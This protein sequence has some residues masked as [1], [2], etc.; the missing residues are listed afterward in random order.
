MKLLLWPEQ[1]RVWI[2]GGWL[3]PTNNIVEIS[4]ISSYQ[5]TVD[6]TTRLGNPTRL[7]TVYFGRDSRICE[8]YKEV[9][10]DPLKCAN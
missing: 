2:C 1:N 8:E 9:D 6:Y 10:Y 3:S 5:I 7:L 4:D